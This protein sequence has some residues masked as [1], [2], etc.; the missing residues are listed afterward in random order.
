[1]PAWDMCPT[2]RSTR[3]CTCRAA[4]SC[5]GSWPAACACGQTARQP[6]SRAERRGK[7]KDMVNISERQAGPVGRAVPGHW[8]G[9]LIIGKD[10]RSQIATLVERTT[11][12]VLLAKVADTRAETVAAALA[13]R[14]AALPAHLWRSLTWDQ[15][16]E[17][18]RHAAFTIA[19]GIPVYF[20]DP[21]HPGS[22][23]PTRTPT[24]FSAST[25]TKA[26]PWTVTPKTTST[27]SPSAQQPAPPDPQ[28]ADSRPTARTTRCRHRLR[29]EAP[30]ASGYLPSAFRL[31]V[32][33]SRTF[34]SA[35][36]RQP[37]AETTQ[38]CVISAITAMQAAR[39]VAAR[40]R[41][42]AGA[43]ASCPE[44]ARQQA[45]PGSLG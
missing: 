37:A 32:T 33:R 31:W 2:R 29:P 18:S 44:C 39:A 7:I 45:G 14:A 3:A 5:A 4:G 41:A 25:S 11:R 19:T 10:G 38:S 24:D 40:G 17:M 30:K 16:H 34:T 20:C 28:L 21:P 23:A 12:Y 13:E 26:R 15:G 36:A 1:M 6:R 22:A 42:A 8:E 35:D 43:P 9:D 27:K